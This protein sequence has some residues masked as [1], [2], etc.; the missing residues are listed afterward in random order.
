MALKGDREELQTDISFFM[1]ETA[2]R[3]FFP[4]LSTVGS[5][6]AMDDA[7]AL[8]TLA[9]NGSGKIPAGCL[10][11]DMVNLDQTR[12]HINWHK[13]EVQ[14]GGKVTLLKK[15][16]VV[17]N[18]ILDTPAVGNKAYLANS[19]YLTAT[20]NVPIVISGVTVGTYNEV[21]GVFLSKKDADG[22]AKVGVNLA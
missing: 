21:V 17:T 6:A 1:N 20:P 7:A 8:V 13:D 19:G 12:Q 15:G 5:G 11:N 18:A 9:A 3:G 4:S 10:L 14:K 16:W 2:S 22:Y